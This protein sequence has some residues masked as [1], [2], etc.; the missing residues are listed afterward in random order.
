M[1]LQ[2][3]QKGRGGCGARPAG[4]AGCTLSPTLKHS[5]PTTSL[6]D[7]SLPAFLWENVWVQGTRYF[8][9]TDELD[10]MCPQYLGWAGGETIESPAS[11]RGAVTSRIS[12]GQLQGS[13]ESWKDV[14]VGVARR[15][16][17]HGRFA[18]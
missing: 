1:S 14:G 9:H 13:R 12:E 7:R 18:V 10:C 15:R 2:G 11:V 3:A 16:T 6:W 8:I 17:Q 4:Q 5:L